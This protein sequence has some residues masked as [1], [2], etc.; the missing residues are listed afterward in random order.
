M[1]K[2]FTSSLLRAAARCIPQSVPVPGST[3]VRCW[4]EVCNYALPSRRRASAVSCPPHDGQSY[5]FQMLQRQVW[6]GH[7]QCESWR[8]PGKKLP[9]SPFWRLVEIPRRQLVT[10]RPASLVAYVR[11][12]SEWWTDVWT[13]S[14]GTE[15]FSPGPDG[16]SGAT[17]LLYTTCRTSNNTYKMRSSY[18]NVFSLSSFTRRGLTT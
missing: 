12:W 4:T 8:V 18:A 17:E 10:D 6:A 9:L 3:A 1:A 16:G 7:S 2:Y 13:G 11:K 5:I 15:S 14:W